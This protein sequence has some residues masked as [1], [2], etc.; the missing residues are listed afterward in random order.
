MHGRLF[1]GVGHRKK[2]QHAGFVGQQGDR[3]TLLLVRGQLCF[4]CRAAQSGF[5]HQPMVAQQ[6]LLAIEPALHTP[7]RQRREILHFCHIAC[8]AER[9][10]FGHRVV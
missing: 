4:Q 3:A 1:D 6:H 7:P 5:M 8:E 9:N 10:R 2:P